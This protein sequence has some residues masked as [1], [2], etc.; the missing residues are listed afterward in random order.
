MKEE[1]KEK[2][3]K[4]LF[5]IL[6]ALIIFFTVLA[7]YS[8]HK[9]DSINKFYVYNENHLVCPKDYFNSEKLQ[10]KL[11]FG[12]IDGINSSQVEQLQNFLGALNFYEDKYSLRGVYG[13][14]T[15]EA[16]AKFQYENNI[17]V[18]GEVNEETIETINKKCHKPIEKED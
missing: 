5:V 10:E 14:A 3:Q 6:I 13:L 7:I 12:D 17:S 18:T 1:Q 2:I 16:V 15:K 4:F 8:P 9:R 11:S